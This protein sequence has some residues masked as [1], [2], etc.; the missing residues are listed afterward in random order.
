MEFDEF[1]AGFGNESLNDA[2]R[3]L[4]KMGR[5]ALEIT[6]QSKTFQNVTGNLSASIGYTVIRDGQIIDEGGFKGTDTGASKGRALAKGEDGLH[7]VAGMDYATFV[8]AK[9]RDVNT[10]GELYLD[11][12]VEQS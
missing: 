8:E 7:F 12:Y 3:N 5:E 6:M 11:Q 10:A 9:G 2:F 4:G 1:I